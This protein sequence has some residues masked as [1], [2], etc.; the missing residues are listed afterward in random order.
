ME[1]IKPFLWSASIE[2]APV[3]IVVCIDLYRLRRLLEHEGVKYRPY[4]GYVIRSIVDA[5]LATEN[6]AIA[7]E[8][9]GLGSLIVGMVF[10]SMTA[11]SRLLGFPAGV[12][13]LLMACIG[14]PDE[15]P[16]QRP[17]WPLD[18]VRHVDRYEKVTNRDITKYVRYFESMMRAGRDHHNKYRYRDHLE[19]LMRVP[20]QNRSNE[21]RIRKLLRRNGISL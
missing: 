14:R 9:F 13:P 8:S 16:R 7:A 3:W 2:N 12:T 4:S 18:M 1:A 5:A 20:L 6:L 10:E 17:R 15:E 21:K 19:R 11:V